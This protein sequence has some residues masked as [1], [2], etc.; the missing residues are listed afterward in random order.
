MSLGWMC[1]FSE[2][3]KHSGRTILL[4]VLR[5]VGDRMDSKNIPIGNENSRCVCW[6]GCPVSGVD[7]SSLHNGI[8]S[9]VFFFM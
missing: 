2:G 8:H 7:F 9:R 4:S 6:L 5:C 1:G 3:V